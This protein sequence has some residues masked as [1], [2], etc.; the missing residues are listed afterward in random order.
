[1]TERHTIKSKD[2]PTAPDYCVICRC[3]GQELPTDCPGWDI[4]DKAKRAVRDGELDFRG[5]IWVHRM[6]PKEFGD[7]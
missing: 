6:L 3:E 1:M 5:D 4:P 2:D 7:D